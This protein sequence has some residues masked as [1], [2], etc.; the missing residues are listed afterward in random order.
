[1]RNSRGLTAISAATDTSTEMV[2]GLR[3]RIAGPHE[4]EQS[5]H[6]R[7]RRSVQAAAPSPAPARARHDSR[8]TAKLFPAAKRRSEKEPHPAQ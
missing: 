6:G 7:A 2:Y 1:M 3:P 5:N 4:T 8:E